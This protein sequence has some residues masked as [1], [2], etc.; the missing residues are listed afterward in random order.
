MPDFSGIDATVGGVVSP[1]IFIDISQGDKE[2]Y[3]VREV[4]LLG[5]NECNEAEGCFNFSALNEF[6]EGVEAVATP[7]ARLG[8]EYDTVLQVEREVFNLGLRLFVNDMRA[9]NQDSYTQRLPLGSVTVSI[10][11]VE[12]PAIRPSSPPG[13]V[14]G[15]A[16]GSFNIA[17][18]GLWGFL[19]GR[20]GNVSL[21]FNDIGIALTQTPGGVPT[22][23]KLILTALSLGAL[24]LNLGGVLG[25]LL[26][27]IAAPILRFGIWVA[28]RFIR[29]VDV[30]IWPLVDA[31]TRLGLTYG[32]GSPFL[33]AITDSALL[34]TDFKPHDNSGIPSSLQSILS[35][36]SN[37][38][39]AANERLIN[40]LVTIGIAKGYLPQRTRM[41]RVRLTLNYLGVSLSPGMI[42]ITGQLT[43]KRRG[44]LCG[45]KAR[46]RFQ[47]EMS[48]RIE[49]DQNATAR[50]L[51]RSGTAGAPIVFGPTPADDTTLKELGLGC[52][53]AVQGVVS[54]DL[55]TFPTLTS[56]TPSVDVTIDNQGPYTA[57]LS[58]VPTDINHAQSLLENA[59]R[60]AHTSAAFSRAQVQVAGSRLLV[61]SGEVILSQPG[62]SVTFASAP[63][64]STTVSDLA[65]G[66]AQP[67]RGFL[68]GDLSS[69]LTLTSSAPQV[70][71]TIGSEG[72]FTL[73]LASV[74]TDL[75]QAQSLL[76]DAIRSA[77]SSSA[78]TQARVSELS[79]HPPALAFN[80]N[81]DV[82]AKVE[83]RGYL[84]ITL[85][86]T[87]GVV[88]ISL[89]AML[90]N[91]FNNRLNQVIAAVGNQILSNSLPAQAGPITLSIPG[92]SPLGPLGIRF[93]L[94][95]AGTGVVSLL[96]F[97]CVP[98]SL[99]Q[100]SS[101]EQ[102]VTV[103]F[104]KSSVEVD[105]EE[106]RLSVELS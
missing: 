43:A 5:Q 101:S 83:V 37:I 48:P 66:V 27:L 8:A 26:R 64:D 58:S 35:P 11:A 4:F 25:W 47:I 36:G 78:F 102:Q 21:Q 68:S 24:D 72:P 62:T 98:L 17:A 104:N 57:I 13:Q 14:F 38:G 92:L 69:F 88:L 16:S 22:G 28:L 97:T 3:P 65:L 76:E 79:A 82:Q 75:T 103:A 50:L 9:T 52:L 89:W 39:V 45:V 49:A 56:A 54:G 105:D 15:D 100:G 94:A 18:T 63:G 31:F 106:L 33:T 67:V 23:I 30:P 73:S 70:N 12:I 80:F 71:V 44:C 60:S 85:W 41:G 2:I 77:H 61:V 10:D 59:V 84:G 6:P 53:Q 90:N 1:G 46:I 87:F 40:Q 20:M 7:G 95:L 19:I 74:P 42:G 86:L 99:Q 29:S 34:A 96:P 55:S 91:V 81:V 32:D 51:F 93:E